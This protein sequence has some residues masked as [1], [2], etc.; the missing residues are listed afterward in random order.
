MASYRTY[1]PV[2]LVL[3]QGVP[4]YDKSSCKI[5]MS[6]NKQ[7]ITIYICIYIYAYT[8]IHMHTH[9]HTYM[10]IYIDTCR[11]KIN[12]LQL[13][14][15]Q[16]ACIFVSVISNCISLTVPIYEVQLTYFLLYVLPEDNRDTQ[17]WQCRLL[18]LI[19]THITY[20]HTHTYEH[21]LKH[22]QK[23]DITRHPNHTWLHNVIS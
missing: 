12:K 20:T 5:C 1:P 7:N 4:L 3:K 6:Q 19:Y 10:H 13:S 8:Y 22:S 16:L 23:T 11:F 14:L 17:V 9:T 18:K 2:K 21:I 15:F